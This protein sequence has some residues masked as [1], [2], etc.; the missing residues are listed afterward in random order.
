MF[1]LESLHRGDS[2][3]FTI[4]HFQYQKENRSKLSQIWNY[5]TFF[6]WELKHEFE[7]AMVNETSVFEPLKFYCIMNFCGEILLRILVVFHLIDFLRFYKFSRFL[8]N[9]FVL[10][11]SC[12]LDMLSCFMDISAVY[13][14]S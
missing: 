6:S 12:K 10:L 1:S 13:M 14:F 7:T 3:G 8:P 11:V 2:N 9:I 4:Y 5:G